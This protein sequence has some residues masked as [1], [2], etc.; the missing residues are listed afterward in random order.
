MLHFLPRPVHMQAL[1][2]AASTKATSHQQR[3][4]ASRHPRR[5]RRR[6]L[7]AQRSNQTRQGPRKAKRRWQQRPRRKLHARRILRWAFRQ[8]ARSIKSLIL[9]LVLAGLP[10]RQRQRQSI[11]SQKQKVGQRRLHIQ[12]APPSPHPTLLHVLTLYFIR[13]APKHLQSRRR[14]EASASLRQR[15]NPM[16]QLRA[17]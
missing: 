8:T 13:S 9:T 5:R 4:K 15:K 12:G 6:R 14:Q 16:T 17:A 7:M 10:Q 2:K 1:L 3:P 11:C